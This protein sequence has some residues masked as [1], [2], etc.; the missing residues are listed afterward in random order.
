M[1][2]FR[3]DRQYVSFVTAETR[4]VCP[5]GRQTGAAAPGTVRQEAAPAAEQAREEA[6]RILRGANS[7]AVDMLKKAKELADD[8]LREAREQARGIREEAKAAGFLEG[9]EDARARAEAERQEDAGALARLTGQLRG[10]YSDQVDSLRTGVI[11]LVMDIARKVIDVK[12][13]ASDQVFLA[14]VDSALERLRQ[15]GSAAIRVSEADY[16]RYFGQEGAARRLR[17]G[18]ESLLVVEEESYAPGDLVVESDGELLDYS[19][20]RQLGRIEKAF[21]GEGA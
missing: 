7:E 16:R 4:P 3:I 19:I 12:L 21:M 1:S 20:G 9:Q 15:K 13:S 17:F 18:Q 8:V 5:A 6:A 10:Q 14:L 2:S 11:A